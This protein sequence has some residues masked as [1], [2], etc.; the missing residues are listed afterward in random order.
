MRLILMGL[1][2]LGVAACATEPPP[3]DRTQPEAVPKAIF[4]GEWYYNLTVTDAEHDNSVA[5]IGEQTATYMDKAF[6]IRWEITKDRLNGHMVPQVYLDPRGTPIK[7]PYGQTSVIL[8]FAIDKHYDIRYRYNPTTRDEL[9]VIEENTDR[10]W[11]ERE[12]MEVDWSKNLATNIWNPTQM[13]VSA[14]DLD[15]EDVASYENVDFYQRGED[16]D[17]D[18]RIDTRKWRPEDGE[19]YLINIDTKESFSTHL[20]TAWQVWFGQYMAPTTVRFRHSLMKVPPP[21]ERTYQPLE[22]RDDF[23]R[24]FGFFRTEFEVRDPERWDST[25]SQKKYLINRFDLSP[26]KVITWY[27]SPTAQEAINAGDTDLLT[28]SKEVVATWNQVLKEAAGRSDDVMVVRENEMLLDESGEPITRADGTRRWK[29]ELGDLRYP[30]I[31]IV[32]K[33]GLAQ[34]LGYGP[35]VPDADTG[36]IIHAN[37]NLY[38]GWVEFVTRRALDQY[39]VAAGNCTLDDIKNGRYF[40]EVKQKCTAGDPLPATAGPEPSFDSTIPRTGGVGGAPAGAQKPN[41]SSL[42]YMTPALQ[43]AYWPKADPAKPISH[44][45]LQEIASGAP[46]PKLK[47]L[48]DTELKRRTSIDLRGFQ[49]IAGTAYERQLL[50]NS[51][52]LSSAPYGE[53]PDDPQVLAALSPASRLSSLP[54]YQEQ[55]IKEMMKRDDPVMFEPAI[56][57]FVQEMKGKPRAEVKKILRRWIYYTGMLHEMGH[58]LGLRHNFSGSVD[59]RN[60]PEQYA[61]EKAKYWDRV[62]AL[63]TKYGAAIKKGD[64][65]SYEAYVR[66]VDEIP[67]SK[68]RYGSSSIMDYHGDWMD[69]HVPAR[70]YDRAALMFGYGKKVEVKNAAGKWEFQPFK[71]GDFEQKDLF[72]PAEKAASGRLVRTYMFCSDEKVFDDVF[73]TQFDRGTTATEI[74]RNYI[75][76][77]QVGYFFTNFKRDRTGFEA[78]RNGYYWRKFMRHYYMIVKALPQLQINAMRYPE[79]WSSIW[80]GINAMAMGPEKRDMKPGYHRTGGEDLLRASLMA[81]YYLMYDVL[82]R[83]NYGYYT[84]KVDT[85]GA[86]F[87]EAT[88]ARYLDAKARNVFVDVGAGWGFADRWDV[89]VD[90]RR[91]YEHLQRIGV[92]TDKQLAYEV[93][94]IPAALNRPLRYEKANGLS[95]WNSIWTNNGSQLWEVTRGLVT[96]NFSHTENPW[97][98]K[99]DAACRADPKKNP[100]TLKAYPVDYLE[101]LAR[102]GVFTTPYPLPTG[103]NRCSGPDEEPVQP[104]MD[105]LFAIKPI[106]YAIAGASHPWYHNALVEKLDSQIKGGL[107]RFDIPPGADYVELLNPAGTKTYQA[108]QNVDGSSISYRLIDNARKIRNRV[109]LVTACIKQKD[110]GDLINAPGTF[111]RTCPEVRSC[112]GPT[113]APAWCEEEGWESSYALDMLK[114]TDV[115]RAEAMLIMMQDMIDLAG[116][117]AWRTPGFL[118]GGD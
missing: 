52:L 30:M 5:F 41:G 42:I 74:V 104:S 109:E 54:S 21:E 25:E 17:S 112:F 35:S 115:E 38:A 88:D 60:F 110:P 37:M 70:S 59:E 13:E 47:M 91:Y 95:F 15:R 94:S 79:F 23:F 63:R 9:N 4:Q 45:L 56:H 53:G 92:E 49:R 27:M 62:E 99:C 77:A 73:C 57:Q 117:Y 50:P 113:A 81:Y 34:P 11:H 108:V 8:S 36:E 19:V 93:L 86:R 58:N 98:M 65:A 31:N 72:D 85:S 6:K 96:D 69:W 102:A 12:Y 68:D 64:A 78:T 103:K 107:H 1:A 51:T 26:G 10:P 43:A 32:F 76:D 48:F 87:W 71:P 40:D 105:A 89:Q 80:S 100:P 46:M 16:K 44:D 118:D 90:P 116:H 84:R 39:D 55:M 61:A 3:L 82:M 7:N 101:G 18:I 67:S 28:W 97:C 75:R 106:F 114:W 66:E 2:M 33:Q 24:R 83:P 111:K 29:Y 14:S 22:Y 20:R